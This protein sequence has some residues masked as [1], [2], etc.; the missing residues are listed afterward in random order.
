MA[1]SCKEVWREVSN[2]IDGMIAPEVREELE[3]HLAQCRHCTAILDGVHNVIVLMADERLFAL[4][5]GFAERTR[6]RLE[7]EF[8]SVAAAHSQDGVVKR[9]VEI[10]FRARQKQSRNGK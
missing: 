2:Y 9:T 6:A 4:P 10:D 3:R 7:K 8:K 5:S 1:M